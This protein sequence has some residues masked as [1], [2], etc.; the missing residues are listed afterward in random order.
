MR[1]PPPEVV[2]GWPAP[3]YDDPERRGPALLIVQLTILPIALTTLILR[4]YV[5]LAIVRRC[6][7]DDWLMCVAMIFGI[8]VTVC[9]ILASQ[10]YGWDVHV[11]D[12][13]PDQLSQGRQ[14]S[15]AAQTMFIFASG[16]AKVSILV[17]YL[18]IAPLDSW[19]RRLTYWTIG[20]VVA[21]MPIFLIVLWTQCNP[22]GD[23]WDFKDGHNC[24]D[25]GPP[26]MA[27]TTLS[28]ITD[29]IVYVLPLPT[30]VGVRLPTFQRIVL[31]GVFSLGFIVVLAG[32]FRT[33]W[34]YEV[35]TQTYDVTWH[36]YMLWIWTA[37]EVN[38]GVICGCVPTL[39]PLFQPQRR[40]SAGTIGPTH[41][42]QPQL[43]P[44]GSEPS[45]VRSYQ[46]SG[47]DS[48][49]GMFR[50][51]VFPNRGSERPSALGLE[52][53]PRRSFLTGAHQTL[54]TPSTTSETTHH[55]TNDS[56]VAIRKV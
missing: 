41:S 27:Q 45:R 13:K 36:G 43:H 44:Y 34:I 14:A 2:E 15:I 5:R 38:S 33:Y 19:F 16:L 48:I 53:F 8:G 50:R 31:L 51:R 1:L 32:C 49:S 52:S 22:P 26:L 3:N 20:L 42:H 55:E 23:Y 24:I 39:R 9:V 37:V 35:V 4:M 7:F 11:W 29:L 10:F 28:V 30:L 46:G 21:L 18:R 56:G 17:S 54:G 6:K 12:L 40:S 47:I 25:E